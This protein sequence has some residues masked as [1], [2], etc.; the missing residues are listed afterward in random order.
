MSKLKIAAIATVVTMLIG[1]CLSGY[2]TL[3]LLR[4][5]TKLYA[6]D[7]YYLSLIHISEPTRPY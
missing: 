5:D 6:W 1:Y 3:L 7:T 2:L 4:L